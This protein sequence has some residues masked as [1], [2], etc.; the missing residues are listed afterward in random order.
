MG[1]GQERFVA[2]AA[3]FQGS[4]QRRNAILFLGRGVDDETA[5]QIVSSYEWRML[6]T[7]RETVPMEE[8]PNLHTMRYKTKAEITAA[9]LW[10]KDEF[11]I[12]SLWEPQE[13]GIGHSGA[14]VQA[15]GWAA[16][17]S[18]CRLPADSGR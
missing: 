12:I 9:N 16:C 2:L 17:S 4:L 5:K 15:A 14:A 6:V 11:P 10:K 8:K 18:R 7:S 13:D 3:E 1:L